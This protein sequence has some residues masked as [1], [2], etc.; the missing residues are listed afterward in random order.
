MENARFRVDTGCSILQSIEERVKRSRWIKFPQS[1]ET[2]QKENEQRTEIEGSFVDYSWK[3]CVQF[4]IDINE[5]FQWVSNNEKN[6]KSLFI[7][8]AV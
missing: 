3:S 7:L 2:N 1:K 6:I 5:K 4:F 8:D